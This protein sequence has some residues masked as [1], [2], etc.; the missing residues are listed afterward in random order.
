MKRCGK[1]IAWTILLMLILAGSER[2]QAQSLEGVWR[3][4]WTSTPAGNRTREHRGSLRVRLI[5]QADGSYQGRFSG[6][7]AVVIPYFYRADVYRQGNRLVST[8]KLGP[9]GSYTMDLGV[10]GDRLLGGWAAGKE[11]GTISLKRR[12]LNYG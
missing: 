1:L 6:R 4:N 11:K 7:F 5:P 3:G 2:C 9:M 8:K 12:S 10:S